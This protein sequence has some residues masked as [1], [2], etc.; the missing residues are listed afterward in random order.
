MRQRV[1]KLVPD[2][3]RRSFSMKFRIVALAV[4]VGIAAI[5]AVTFIGVQEELNRSAES[6]LEA[7]ATA[8]S[9]NLEGWVDGLRREAALLTESEAVGHGDIPAVSA[10]LDK[11]VASETLDPS[12]LAVH[13]VDTSEPVI[14]ASSND[15]FVDVN[16]QAEG[17]PWARGG[18]DIEGQQ[19]V[20]SDV[21]PGPNVDEPVVA[22]LAPVERRDN[23]ALVMMVNVGSRADRLPARSDG[24]FT[25]VVNADGTVLMSHR[26]DEILTQNVANGDKTGVESSAIERGLD[27]ES[28]YTQ[29]DVGD[30]TIVM[31]FAPVKGVD[32]VVTARTTRAEAFAV[33]Q[34]VTRNVALLLV[35][36]VLGFLVVAA[37]LGR[38]TARALDDIS[39]TASAVAAGDIHTEF[40]ES[41]RI[42]ELGEVQSAFRD[43]REY[44]VT[45]TEQ[46]EAL[47]DQEFDAPILEE[48]VPG[49][50]GTAIDETMTDLEA[51]M[52]DIETARDEAMDAQRDAER[53][54]TELDQQARQFRDV[55]DEV[56]AGDLT[57]RLDTQGANDSM[58]AIAEHTN[59]TLAEL[60]HTVA[61]VRA[62]AT[63]VEVSAEDICT[64]AEEIQTTS[65]DVAATT[66]EIA[67]G[68]DHQNEYLDEAFGEVNDLSATVEEIAA[69]SQEVAE[70]STRAAALGRD[71]CE[72]ATAAAEEIDET[73]ERVRRVA[74]EVSRL[75]EE[76]ERIGEIVVLIDDIA[77]QTNLLAL[78]ANIEAARAG[79]G[80]GSDGFAVVADEIK[81][82]ATE[83]SERTDEIGEIISG[84]QTSTNELAE[85]MRA[86]REGMVDGA[87]EVDETREIFEDVIDLVEEAN[88]GIH[89]ID[90]A[91][92]QQA[93]ATG[94]IVAMVDEV[95]DI[96][97]KTAE[98]TGDLAAAAE[99]QSAAI[100][101]VT[102]QIDDLADRADHL[103]ALTADFTVDEA[104]GGLTE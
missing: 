11:Q 63:D 20:V 78:N 35:V 100:T 38:P 88:D 55:M 65:A 82:L 54:A 103:E 36:S 16:P 90:E 19:P 102:E 80:Q 6:R 79:T 72:Q 85:D 99:E 10:Y 41:N 33:Q 31:G 49:P 5:G 39:Q 53:L 3:V 69:S 57:R 62:V 97:A 40:G 42:D 94:E 45:V 60:E 37:T 23:R 18:V 93:S 98:E 17:V 28:G 26:E 67:D 21:F 50:L 74:Q 25:R 84:V 66:Q 101:S 27:G 70:Q 76:M 58:T 81:A 8:Q 68:A 56:R 48:S 95:S 71:G 14:R 44:V 73:A 9:A 87:S 34:F 52:T 7:S 2:L 24:R 47:A 89:A 13:Y 51:S 1:A 32:W 46:L 12:V 91:T 30:R 61:G 83:T 4:V 22:V 77:E 86:V 64:S 104:A 29:R 92:D 59:E 75:D 96:S 15:A 43:I